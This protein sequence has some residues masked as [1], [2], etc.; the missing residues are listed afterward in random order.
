MILHRKRFES[1]LVVDA[2]SAVR[3]IQQAPPNRY[4]KPFGP[5]KN[6]VQR[7]LLRLAVEH[8]YLWL[9]VEAGRR[10]H[11]DPEVRRRHPQIV[12]NPSPIENLLPVLT[13]PKAWEYLKIKP[14]DPFT[15]QHLRKLAQHNAVIAALKGDGA[16]ERGGQRN[17]AVALV[18]FVAQVSVSTVNRSALSKRSRK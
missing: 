15:L 18:S 1:R 5:G 10:E 12:A 16:D 9:R 7:G 2:A 17:A 8:V 3:E 14:G 4:W 13:N 6:D 11:P